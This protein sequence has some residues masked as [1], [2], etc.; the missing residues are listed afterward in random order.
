[1]HPDDGLCV[2]DIYTA[3]DDAADMASMDDF[4][5][6]ASQ[7][8]HRCLSDV[9]RE[10]PQGGIATGIGKIFWA[11]DCPFLRLDASLARH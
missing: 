5:R 7:L 4:G 10:G 3:S 6:A 8:V 1:M 9:G 2:F 11:H